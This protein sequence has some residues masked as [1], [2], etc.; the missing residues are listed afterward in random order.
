MT[1]LPVP[2]Y[3]PEL[4]RAVIPWTRIHVAKTARRYPVSL[5]DLWDESISALIRAALHYDE[6]KGAF[7]G[8]AHSAIHRA[9]WRYCVSRVRDS[10]RDGCRRSLPPVFLPLASLHR[11]H[12]QSDGHAMIQA[13]ADLDVPASPHDLAVL[14]DAWIVPSPET[15]LLALEEADSCD[16]ATKSTPVLTLRPA[17]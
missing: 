17:V 16:S 14:R 1:H 15:I 10:A 3:L 4:A 9:C 6:T 8:Y 12:P 13:R 2:G 11:P 5:E 7:A